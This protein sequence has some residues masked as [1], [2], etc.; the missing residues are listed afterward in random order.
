MYGSVCRRSL[1]VLLVA[2]A[3]ALP[4]RLRADGAG[5][6]P[7][8]AAEPVPPLATEPD[9]FTDPVSI[10]GQQA[11]GLYFNGP[12][13]KRLGVKGII[14]TVKGANLDAVVLDIKDGEGRVTYDT[15][16][17]A[18]IPQK[19]VFVKDFRAF[20]SELK[21]AGIYTIARVVCFSDP[22]LPRADHSRAVLDN[23]ES[24][25]GRIWADT[26]HRNTWLDPYN[27]R[28]HEL[29]ASI[30]R[31]VERF[32]FDEIQ[33]DYVR[34][35]VDEATVF[36]K[37]P[38]QVDKP[39]REVILSLLRRVDAA[40]SIPINTDVF[41]LTALR[42]G[43]PAGL[44]QSLED[45]VPHVE[46]FSPMLYINGMKTWVSGGSNRAERLVLAA[47]SKLR[48]RVGH[49]P[50]L[51]PFL[52]AFANGADYYT[53]QFIAEQIR[54]ARNAGS[55]GFLFWHPGSS[56]GLVQAG[57]TGPARA[58]MPF[59]LGERRAWREQAWRDGLPRRARAEYEAEV[60][61]SKEPAPSSG[62]AAARPADSSSAAR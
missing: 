44:G 29:I 25:A 2:L 14:R 5:P 55:D 32:G 61:A 60:A 10:Q 33:L 27:E 35:P 28:N 58:L 48:E 7:R 42:V 20:V 4:L 50:V 49:G 8:P 24:R 13:M 56:Y 31:D 11:R 6:Q 43:D 62:G 19:R 21:D 39:R 51:R 36:A 59:P 3:L 52:Q 12:M 54:G 26:G 17:E 53:P 30:A 57:A 37:F 47:M 34:F 22:N 16:I 45:W 9:R 40:I 38:A 23:R 41:G 15:Q 46:V 18:I 1:R